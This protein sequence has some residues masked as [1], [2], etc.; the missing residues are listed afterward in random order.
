[1]EENIQQE[2]FSEIERPRKKWGFIRPQF[3]QRRFTFTLTRERIALF[4]IGFV[5][6][7]VIA[8]S[9]GV[10]SGK[11]SKVIV[12][13]PAAAAKNA[14]TVKQIQPYTIFIDAYRSRIDADKEAAYL[15]SKGY[16]TFLGKSGV[17]FKL[18]AGSYA[19]IK[20]ARLAYQRLKIRYKDANIA[21]K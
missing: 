4:I 14:N 19:N 15:R 13:A 12:K 2:L 1:M 7:L 20:D 9:I 5:I 18:Y 16:T 10:E 17:Y 3:V 21:K 6:L 8:Y 11:K